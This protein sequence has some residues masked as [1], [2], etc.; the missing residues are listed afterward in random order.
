[1]RRIQIYTVSIVIATVSVL[2]KGEKNLGGKSK[3]D[4]HKLIFQNLGGMTHI[5]LDHGLMGGYCQII[6]II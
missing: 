1:M 5:S 2:G 4:Y 3:D 6:H